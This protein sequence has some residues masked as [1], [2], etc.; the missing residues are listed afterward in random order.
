MHDGNMKSKHVE[1]KL[2]TRD[3]YS[4]FDVKKLKLRLYFK[5]S[6]LYV[7]FTI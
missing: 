4:E 3:I 2:I 5:L 6:L 1:Y 7:N